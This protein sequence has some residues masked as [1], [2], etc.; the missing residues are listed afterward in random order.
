LVP[1]L[2]SSDFHRRLYTTTQTLYI[3]VF[4]TGQHQKVTH[5]KKDDIVTIRLNRGYLLHIYS[6]KGL[7]LAIS[8][9]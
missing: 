1:T 3:R 8:N 2:V 4:G 6:V 5:S 9:G 7:K